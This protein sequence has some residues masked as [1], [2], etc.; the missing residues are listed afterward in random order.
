MANWKTRGFVLQ[1][2]PPTLTYFDIAKKKTKVIKVLDLASASS[3]RVC[4]AVAKECKK[5]DQ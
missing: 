4:K 5:I 1:K 3:F 2:D